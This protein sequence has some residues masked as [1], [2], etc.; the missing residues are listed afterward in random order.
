MGE[1]RTICLVGHSGSGKT[2]LAKALIK[3]GGVEAALDASPEA[4]S[5]GNSV[6]LGLGCYQQGDARL[7]LI[8]TPGFGEFIEEVYKGLWAAETALLVINGEKGVEVQTE[9]SWELISDAQ[10]PALAFVNRMDLPNASYSKVIS[11][12]RETLGKQFAPVEWVIRDGGRWV[13]V[14][15]LV[16]QKARYFG[17]GGLSDI[18]AA[19]RDEAQAGREALLEG[20]AEVDD[21][22]MMRFLEEQP[23][24]P[25][26][27]RIA[28]HTGMVQRKVVPVL[29]GSATT[30]EGV[31]MLLQAI[32]TETPSFAETHPSASGLRALVFN[33]AA[34]QYLGAM[35]FVKVLSGSL[36]EGTAF[37]NISRKAKERVR[38]LLRIQGGKAE[39]IS[40]AGPGDLTVLTK[41]EGFSLGD[42][43]ADGENASPLEFVKFPQP[44]FSRSL[45]PVSQADEEKMS[46]ALHEL[47]VTKATL[48]VGRDDVTHEMVLSGM[49]DVQLAVMTARLKNRYG[50][51]VQT[52]RP[53]VPYKETIM[54]AAEGQY[55]HKKQ[56][57]GRGQFAEVHLRVEPLPRGTGFEFVDEVRGGVIPNQ[58]I[59]SV[60]KG[61]MEALPE[62]ILAKYPV[63]DI[64]AAVFYGSFH[65]VDSSDIAFKIAAA[66]AFKLALQQASPALLEPV[67]KLTAWTP[68]EFTG[69]LMSSLSGKRGRIL[70]MQP[71]G[72]LERIEAEA[73]LAEVQDYALELKSITQGR[74]TFQLEFLHYQPVTSPKLAEE[75]LK[76]EGRALSAQ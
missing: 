40:E 34:D 23:I 58:F 14:I 76:R 36:K 18:P 63:S 6:D 59:P 67:M 55:K 64:R 17:K 8:D 51:S 73:P 52:N 49:G 35:A 44:I 32:Q 9:K 13:G 69:D 39:K 24:S 62:G 56:S 7:Y 27:V 31:K 20:L 66:Q 33:A 48:K 70:G 19:L 68:R 26:E 5:R 11:E 30:G 28:L 21:Q 71:D 65:P 37:F 74:A 15:D 10:K 57:G 61:V 4:Q 38:D 75:L 3:E 41:L 53:H 16:E 72:R 12:V 29:C 47:T 22:L 45:V 43:F 1:V 46:T 50:V 25:D 54:K 60:E 2:A 42:V